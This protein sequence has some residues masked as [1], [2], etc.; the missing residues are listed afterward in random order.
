MNKRIYKKILD[1]YNSS[2]HSALFHLTISA[3]GL[4]PYMKEFWV[5]KGVNNE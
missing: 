5:L 2:I 4:L 1:L 3:E